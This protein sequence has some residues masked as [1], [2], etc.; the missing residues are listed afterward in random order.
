MKT[1]LLKTP[2]FSFCVVLM[3]LLISV[4]SF[5]QL[6]VSPDSNATQLANSLAG[7]GVVVSNAKLNCPGDDGNRPSGTFN[8]AASNIGITNGILLTTGDIQWAVGPNNLT[9]NGADN[10]YTFTDSDLVKI[11]PQAIYDVCILEFD[12]K[13]S[14]DTMKFSFAFG[15][16]EY[17]EFVNQIYN[18]AF[19]IFVT[20]P[21][22]SGAVYNSYNM[23]LI[24]GTT[25]AVTI[26]NVNNGP[27]TAGSCPPT[28]TTGPCQNCAYYTDNCSGATVQYDGFTTPI[29]VKLNVVPCGNYHLKLAIADAGD[30]GY[31]S[32]VL[33]AANSLACNNYLTVTATSTSVACGKSNGTAAVASVTGGQAPYTYAWNTT[34]AQTTQT[35]TGLDPGVYSVLV[36]DAN[37]CLQGAQTVTV[38]LDAS[39]IPVA[40]ANSVNICSGQS[41]TITASGGGNY[42]WNT[43]ATTASI[44]VS[45]TVTTS[46]SVLVSVGTCTATA[47]GTVAVQPTP[48][49]SAQGTTIPGSSTSL[50]ATGGTTYTWVPATGLSNPNIS[51]PVASPVQTTQYCVYVTNAAG[52]TDSACITVDYTCKDIFVPTAFSPNN[53]GVNEVECVLGDCFT[54]LQF[55][56]YDRWGEKVF[57]TTDPSICWNGVYK[58][59]LMNTGVFVYFLKATLLNGTAVEKKG[60]ISLIR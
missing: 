52:C 40:T 57:E 35:A 2:H 27:G 53:D 56:I 17:P 45:P 58:S 23:A 6:Q 41:T 50:T 14:C 31:D 24:P 16:E 30:N 55:A 1:L 34:P 42:S 39:T 10:S 5:S 7:P 22:P 20:G 11:E 47:A 32:G 33:F 26:N 28:A 4:N 59:S 49:A 43:G 46:Y 8:G 25:T 19:G 44:F 51:N 48:V 38:S 21:N 18:D 37:G 3:L 15:S 13:P 29:T 60:N 36:V 12:L 9:M 54:D